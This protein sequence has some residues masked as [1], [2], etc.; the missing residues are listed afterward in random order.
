MSLLPTMGGSSWPVRLP[1]LLSRKS[2]D[3][4][5]PKSLFKGFISVDC[6]LSVVYS[7]AQL[8]VLSTLT[9]ERLAAWTFS[10]CLQPE[11][12]RQHDSG[13]AV[14]QTCEISCCVDMLPQ[15]AA[16]V[17][18][19]GEKS[20][21]GRYL[22]VGLSDGRVCIFN[23]FSSKIVRCISL[24]SRITAL[25]CLTTLS[26]IP[27]HLCEEL[28]IMNGLMAVGSQ[29]GLLYLVDF[30]LD[31]ESMENRSDER[32]PSYPFYIDLS[33]GT[34][35]VANQRSV[36]F[37]RGQ[38]LCVSLDDLRASKKR[39]NVFSYTNDVSGETVHFPETGV[40]VSS[41]TFIP[42]IGG[43]L[44][45]FNFGAW[46]FWNV[47]TANVRGSAP[48]SLEYSSAYASQD[49]PVVKFC[50]Q[51]PEDDPRNFVYV[52]VLR[53]DNDLD[54]EEEKEAIANFATITLHAL[55]FSSKD[56][57]Y[58]GVL[59]SGLV[60]CQKRF[61]HR[62][63]A[64]SSEEE[65]STQKAKGSLCLA[66]S[67][68]PLPSPNHAGSQGLGAKN[69]ASDID[70]GQ[71]NLGLCNFLWE[72]IGPPNANHDM[73]AKYFLGTFDL[74][75]WYQAQMPSEI[76]L[77][78]TSQCSYFSFCSLDESLVDEKHPSAHLIDCRVDLTTLSRY[79]SSTN[80]EQHFYPSSLAFNLICFLDFGFIHATHL[81]LQRKILLELRS[82]GRDS[83]VEPARLY[84]VC[85][86]AG[87]VEEHE[88]GE[89]T[90]DQQRYALLS[91]ALDHHLTDFL[92]SCLLHWSD[93]K[94]KTIWFFFIF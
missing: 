41:L 39:S 43:V 92:K 18:S 94:L 61:H 56:D 86:I 48:I 7:G 59:Y 72:V 36:A 79:T 13:S 23:I 55:A 42:Q 4:N 53:G 93:G 65:S 10:P 6:L 70:D 46:Q 25:Q 38:H 24:P 74:N 3:K 76:I 22:C 35:K 88:D 71:T 75:A 73:P 34:E 82:V 50:F 30:A 63:D 89:D 51:E 77:T 44:A 84:S 87:L 90:V 91:I 1:K 21:D 62:L 64:L 17:R 40:V 19:S 33:G 8:E 58:A 9:G 52:W 37:Q 27:N 45:G 20:L 15:G 68:M 66:G 57:N 29:G 31:E 28:A 69:D 12:A 26:S 47:S 32:N 2:F 78:P 49:L 67:T 60:S 83:L 81:G 85:A 54:S 5:E 16:L 80:A 14:S 11:R